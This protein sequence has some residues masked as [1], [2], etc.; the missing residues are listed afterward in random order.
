[1]ETASTV[2]SQSRRFQNS[3]RAVR[4]ARSTQPF[5]CGCRGGRT[6]SATPRFL[7]ASSKPAMNSLPPSTWTDSSGTGR[8]SATSARK[9][10]ALKAVAREKAR[11]TM[12]RLTGQ[13][14]RNSL[15]EL[16]SRETVMWSIWTS[17]P[18]RSAL[19][20]YFHRR[21][22]PLNLR[23]RLGLARP[24]QRLAGGT[25]PSAMARERMRPTVDTLSR[26]PWRSSR[27]WTRA[28]PMNGCLRRMAMTASASP[29]LRAG[30]RT[31]RGR[32]DFGARPRWPPAASAAFHRYIV[33]RLTPTSLKAARSAQPAAR[34]PS[35]RRIADRRSRAS[36]GSSASSTL[37]LRYDL[38][39]IDSI[40]MAR[41]STSDFAFTEATR[42]GA[43]GGFPP[44]A[45]PH[46]AIGRRSAISI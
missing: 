7:Q 35:N 10:A 19:S 17:W 43:G 16:P 38:I 41:V 44:P 30:R 31:R 33:R 13:M 4:L 24:S 8:A 42:S 1:M 37:K 28:L 11:A 18:G 2:R 21:A 45:P 22:Q 36:A 5:H 23:G 9:R 15:M 40:R 32:V 14:A 46:P 20:P 27:R 25:A 12:N 3:M 6:R 39:R 34:S 29:G 26:R